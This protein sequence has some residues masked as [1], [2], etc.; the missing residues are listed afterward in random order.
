MM[1]EIHARLT[2]KPSQQLTAPKLRR[3]IWWLIAAIWVPLFTLPAFAAVLAR[4][5]AEDPL[6]IPPVLMLLALVISSLAGATALLMRIDRELSAAPDKPLLRP[7]LMCASHM[8]GAWLAGTLAFIVSRQGAFDVWTTLGFVLAAS[9]ANAKFIESMLE[10][11]L[12]GRLGGP[13]GEPREQP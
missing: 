13:T 7:W 10:K 12:P 3:L 6:N 1:N 2:T 9:F 4:A 11:F 8:T 5:G